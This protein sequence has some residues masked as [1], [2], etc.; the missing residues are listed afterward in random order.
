VHGKLVR[1]AAKAGV[2]YIMPNAYGF[3][4]MNR[5]LT[6]E[7][8]MRPYPG[9]GAEI[10]GLG[11]KWVIMVC[12]MWFEWS[13]ALGSNCF[14]LDIK[15]KKATFYDE[16]KTAINVSTWKQ[17]GRALAALLSLKELPKDESDKGPT[18]ARWANKPLYITSWKLSQRDMLDSVQRVLGDTDAEWEIGYEKTDERY[19][20]GVEAMKG[21]DIGGFQRAMYARVFFPNGGGDFE[22]SKGIANEAIGLPKEELDEQMKMVVEKVESGWN[23]WATW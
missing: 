11:A 23:P 8:M 12:G 1:A 6:E 18:V 5:K 15:N 19:K 3:D 2:P 4:A 17:C 20:K 9:Y 16:G 13:L 21:G 14:G 7:A 22:T 10:E